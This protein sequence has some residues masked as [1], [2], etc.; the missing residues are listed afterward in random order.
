MTGLLYT[1]DERGHTALRNPP[2]CARFDIHAFLER[3]RAAQDH[4]ASVA[5]AYRREDLGE[6]VQVCADC[7]CELDITPVAH[8]LRCPNQK[9]TP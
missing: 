9:G 3:G 6:P 7:R 4:R 5:N 8:S 1:K 2:S